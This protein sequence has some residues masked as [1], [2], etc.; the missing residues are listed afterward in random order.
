[1]PI[2][3]IF[4][5][6]FPKLGPLQFDAVLEESEERTVTYTENPVEFGANYQDHR[7]VQPTRYYMVGAVSNTPLGFGLDDL[8]SAGLGVAGT[9]VGGFGGALISGIGS[10]ITSSYLSGSDDTRSSSAW[11]ILCAM[12]AS[13]DT[14]DVQSGLGIL[15]SMVIPRISYRRVP[16]NE[17]GLIF[18]AEMRQLITVSTQFVKT[19]VTVKTTAEEKQAQQSVNQG[20]V[21][22][23]EQTG[24]DY[25]QKA[26]KLEALGAKVEILRQ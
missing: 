2:Q 9:I 21:R 25:E 5:R 19:D 18:I 14:F 24:T 11:G 8:A 22:A 7:I 17:G 1:M 23:A 4:S 26:A 16:E 20:E 6:T 15:K 10:Y 12:A 3:S 13:G